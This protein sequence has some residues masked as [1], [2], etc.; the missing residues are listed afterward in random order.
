MT[1]ARRVG[2]K[3]QCDG[4]ILCAVVGL[5]ALGANHQQIANLLNDLGLE[6]PAGRPKWERTHVRRLCKTASADDVR[7]AVAE[8]PVRQ[9]V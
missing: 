6:T 1:G 3:L 7:D 5:H 9:A 8:L 2:R 4:H